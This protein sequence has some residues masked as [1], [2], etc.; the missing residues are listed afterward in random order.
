MVAEAKEQ[1]IKK[2]QTKLPLWHKYLLT[3]DEAS[4]YFGI[5]RK[6]LEVFLKKHEDDLCVKVGVK[7]LVKREVFE[8][9]INDK[10]TTI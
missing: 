4:I 2:E 8:K 5:G 1:H 9:F 7:T 6:R 10:V 3:I